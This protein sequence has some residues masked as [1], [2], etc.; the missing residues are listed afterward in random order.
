MADGGRKARY[1]FSWRV[2]EGGRQG[3]V[4]QLQLLLPKAVNYTQPLNLKGGRRDLVTYIF[5]KRV[6]FLR[7]LESFSFISFFLHLG[8]SLLVP[9]GAIP[10]GK[11][12]EM[13]L[14]INK[15]ENTL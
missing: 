12:Y 13:Y 1:R 2:T 11:F 8:V 9:H 10:Q 3:K 14:I 7:G 15:A 4:D 5:V 6:L